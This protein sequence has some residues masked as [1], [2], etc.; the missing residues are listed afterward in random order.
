MNGTKSESGYMY[1]HHIQNNGK[2]PVEG[3]E[4]TYNEMVYLNDSLLYSTWDLG[5][6]KTVVLPNKESVAKPPPPN[7]EMLL[8]MSVGDSV[9]V[10][11]SLD[12]IPNLPA[13]LKPTD[14]FHYE[15]SLVSIKDKESVAAETEKMK[16]REG[17]VATATGAV[18][19]NYEAGKLKTQTTPS[20]MKYIIHEEGTGKQATPG[21]T[22]SVNYSGFLLDKSNFDNSYKRGRTFDFPLGASRVIKGWDEG[23]ALLKEGSKATFFIPAE[24]GYGERGSPPNIPP[25]SELVFYIELLKVN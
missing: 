11:Q 25:N 7:Y 5:S 14:Q 12:S 4:V 17:D 22:V 21:K 9:T 6:A 2:V 20:G 23:V 13:Q 16:A 1:T 24:L 8:I 15:M 19:D 3:D 10:T 18:I